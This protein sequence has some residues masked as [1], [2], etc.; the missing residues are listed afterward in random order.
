MNQRTSTSWKPLR[1]Y[2]EHPETL[3]MKELVSLHRVWDEQKDKI[4]GRSAFEKFEIEMS[5]E[6]AVETGLI[7]RLYDL[8]SGITNSMI[9]HGIREDLIPSHV[10]QDSKKIAAMIHDH[11]AT[12]EGLSEF[13]KRGRTLTPSYIRELH[14]LITRH[15]DSYEAY[16]TLGNRRLV[17]LQIGEFKK[18]PNN[19]TLPN[20]DIY[21]YCPPE[22]V[23]SEVD[24]LCKLHEKHMAEYVYPEVE[25]AWLHHRFTR[26][27]PFPDG[28]GRVARA[29]ASLVFVRKGW[30]PL[31]VRDRDRDEY[32][33][34]LQ[35]ADSGHLKPLVTFFGN[36][37]KKNFVRALSI[38][39]LTTRVSR[40]DAQLEETRGRLQNKRN[41]LQEELDQAAEIAN[42][43]NAYA[44]EKTVELK[45]KLDEF[46]NPVLPRKVKFIADRSPKGSKK[47][48]FYKRQILEVANQL[49]YYADT[50]MHRSWVRL[51][52]QDGTECV[53]LFSF[54]GYGVE[55]NGLLACSSCWFETVKS[56]EA[57]N[58]VSKAVSVTREPFIIN[59]QESVREARERF[60]IWFDEC[61]TRTIQ[62]FEFGTMP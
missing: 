3:A 18:Y 17:E 53:V 5:R 4:K 12:L 48:L 19:P 62:L 29:I 16:D 6:W 43:L 39:K 59:Y 42:E 57:N 61:A 8:P 55:F 41:S 33:D 11:Q 58:E 15:Q 22:H 1:D 50:R 44:D 54:H 26:I 40:Y 25:A 49:D 31:V 36:Y 56:D 34:A 2:E 13:I 37:Q 24:Q 28:N 35:S 23:D 27:H 14:A 38:T 47:D 45:N 10:N 52:I 21:Q 20:G 7:E 32:F 9:E 46:L 60:D 30:F 51:N